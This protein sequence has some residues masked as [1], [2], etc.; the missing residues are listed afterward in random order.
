MILI[1]AL[2]ALLIFTLTVRW[3]MR[4]ADRARAEA[5]FQKTTESLRR[6]HAHHMAQSTGHPA[7]RAHRDAW[8]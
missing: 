7:G 1:I 6:A 4:A 3:R 2:V 5:Q 8:K